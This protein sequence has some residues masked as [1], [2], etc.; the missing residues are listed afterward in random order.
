MAKTTTRRT[1]NL[2][3]PL[4]PPKTYWDKIYDWLL[5]R[6]KV[7]IM[8][9]EVLIVI[10]FFSK[11][12][13]DNYGKN[14]KQQYNKI[15]TEIDVESKNEIEFR[16][17]QQKEIDYKNLWDY[18]NQY[19]VVIAEVYS[20][21]SPNAEV[22]VQIEN[23]KITINGYLSLTESKDLEERIKQSETFQNVVADLSVESADIETNQGQFNIT[24]EVSKAFS[25]RAK[26]VPALKNIQTTQ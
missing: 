18:S 13:V 4:E 1:F 19:S 14:L 26:F 22:A 17:Y 25:L 5:S 12:L 15:K 11:V 21:L 2:L 7:I 24:A 16:A 3:I 8:V 9:I 6:A 23:N 20:Y 10:T